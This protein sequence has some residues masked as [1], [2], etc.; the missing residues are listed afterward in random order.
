MNKI[1]YALLIGCLAISSAV[2]CNGEWETTGWFARADWTEQRE[3]YREEVI[4]PVL[5][6]EIKKLEKD[7]QW[8]TKEADAWV[9]SWYRAAEWGQST[10]YE[11]QQI[12]WYR[13]FATQAL[14]DKQALE[15]QGEEIVLGWTN[16]FELNR[17]ERLRDKLTEAADEFRKKYDI[18][19]EQEE[20]L[21]LSERIS[22]GVFF[23]SLE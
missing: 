17:K 1:A 3:A 4:Y 14:E 22:S 21:V 18:T 16:Q 13:K 8:A 15:E 6:A 23:S 20:K 5:R 12:N 19:P 11:G 9:K 7:A 2:N 10:D